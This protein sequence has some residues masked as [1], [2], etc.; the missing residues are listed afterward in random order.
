M[1]KKIRS[2]FVFSLVLILLAFLG[3]YCAR[4]FLLKKILERS[5]NTFLRGSFKDSIHIESLTLDSWL[6]IHAK[7]ISGTIKTPDGFIPI[8]VG[9]MDSEGSVLGSLAGAPLLMKVREIKMAETKEKGLSTYLLIEHFPKSSMDIRI[10][11]QGLNLEDLRELNRSYLE[12]FSGVLKGRIRISI[13]P[14]RE[15]LMDMKL[16]IKEPGGKMPEHTL[17]AL[18]PYVPPKVWQVRNSSAEKKDWIY[19]QQASVKANLIS[20][21]LMK[22][23]FHLYVKDYNMNLNLNLDLR[24]DEKNGFFEL[25]REIGIIKGQK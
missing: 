5:L 19:F 1:N 23:L 14:D 4:D 25:I 12:G 15:P 20:G 2:G 11:I 7:N 10:I 24:M 13:V 16:E 9:R 22:I 17:E 6:Q 18:K 8:K 3:V 21:N